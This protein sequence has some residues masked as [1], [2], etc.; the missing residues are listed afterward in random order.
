[1]PVGKREWRRIC[2]NSSQESK[3]YVDVLATSPDCPDC[4][5][6]F[7]IQWSYQISDA[8]IE[9]TQSYTERGIRT[10]WISRKE[11]DY[12]FFSDGVNN[13]NLTECN[14]GVYLESLCDNSHN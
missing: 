2:R 12:P 13:F 4:R 9:R 14:L 11:V 3:R 8:Y 7:E 6:A 5:I 1:M 10:Y